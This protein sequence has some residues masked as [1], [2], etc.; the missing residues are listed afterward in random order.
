VSDSW[1]NV[2]DK[3]ADPN[4]DLFIKPLGGIAQRFLQIAVNP[5]PIADGTKHQAWGHAA[6]DG[7][8]CDF[9]EFRS[10]GMWSG[11]ARRARVAARNAWATS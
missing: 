2:K 9:T 1:E 8:G 10:S 11:E 5:I 7:S 4:S 3:I 6:L